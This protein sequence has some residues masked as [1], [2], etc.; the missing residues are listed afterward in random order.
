MGNGDGGLVILDGPDA[1]GKTTLAR[2]LLDGDE[3]GYMHLSYDPSWT[4]PNRTLWKLQYFSLVKAAVRW[5]MGKLTVIDRHWMSEQIYANVYRG[6]SDLNAECRQ[7]DRVVQRLCG[8][9]VICAPDPVSAADRHLKM[10]DDRHEMYPPSR[11]IIEV[12]EQF[13]ELWLGG[14]CNRNDYVAH[15]IRLGG[16]RV[17]DDAIH[18]DLDDGL[19]LRVVCQR[20]RDCSNDLRLDQ[21]PL[22][23]EYSKGNYLGHPRYAKFLFVGERINPTK[24]GRWPFVDHGASSATLS[25]VLHDLHFD[26]RQAMWTNAYAQDEHVAALYYAYS[27]KVISLGMSASLYLEESS[28]P[29]VK[30]FHPAFAQRFNKVSELREQLRAALR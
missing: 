8:V 27:P 23:F 28:I 6:G 2:A 12:A 20:I 24:S 29:H 9:Y 17:R 4:D 18:Y 25:N 15:L 19:D 21:Y 5:G 14:D 16:M 3:G 26:E 13:R 7:W 11:Q 1:V 30:V 22:A 10:N